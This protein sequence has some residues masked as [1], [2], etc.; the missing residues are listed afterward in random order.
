VKTSIALLLVLVLAF[1][2][3]RGRQSVRLHLRLR[4]ISA[5]SERLQQAQDADQR[6]R[7]LFDIG[8][9]EIQPLPSNR[10]VKA[11]AGT[12]TKHLERFESEFVV[13]QLS[14]ADSLEIRLSKATL[15]NAQ[16]RFADSL[17]AVTVDDEKWV[18]AAGEDQSRRL[19][20]IL[21][22]RG[23][24][25]YGLR[26]W[27][28]ALDHYQQLL[29]LEPNQLHAMARLGDC[30]Y[31]LGRTNEAL[32]AYRDLAAS[33]TQH[34]NILRNQGKLD[35]AAGHYGQA[36]EIQTRLIQRKG[37]SEL[38]SELATSYTNRGMAF[39]V[40]SKLAEAIADYGKAIAIQTRLIEHEGRHELSNDLAASHA[41][42]GNVLL[43]QGQLDAAISE[44]DRA[45]E[46]RTRLVEQE[47]RTELARDLAIVHSNRG[48]AR[49]GQRRLA[50]AIEDYSKAI[51]IHTRLAK[52]PRHE[53]VAGDLAM[54]HTNR[55]NVLLAQGRQDAAI[56][57]YDKAIE[58]QSR[59]V[60]RGRSELANDLAM[61]HIGRGI[62]RQTT[63]KLDAAI[64][65]YG[66][67]IEIRTRLVQ[68]GQSAL[69][70]D[71][72]KIHVKRG[73]TLLA[74]GRPKAAAGDYEKAIAIQTRLVQQQGRR[75]L[76]ADFAKSLRTAAW[77][78]ATHPLES[79]RDGIKS[80][81]Y[82]YK[83]CELT[84]WKDFGQIETLAAAYAETG[85]FLDAVTWQEK[86]VEFAS[87]DKSAQR[88]RLEL[89]KS[90]K[91]FRQMHAETE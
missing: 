32:T 49:R 60:K 31:S 56:E 20:R 76:A 22:V 51:E 85:N 87:Q 65:D 46:I 37:Q 25:F 29:L 10:Q 24:S 40:Q 17:A 55:G 78:Y 91:P 62:A 38:S 50:A 33:H 8:P 73:D 6:P 18:R 88:A 89:Y 52:Q 15:A 59:L 80:R 23:D 26:Q 11:L 43:V 1:L 69:A 41:N 71:L 72:A 35:R 53:D 47:G 67:A 58:I 70:N 90:G 19:A 44:Y 42:R 9:R 75:E 84:E 16:G 77:M 74:K 66:K 48:N 57:D 13:H 64:E 30:Q 12:L 4:E 5:L 83:A 27:A 21:Q 82:A 39:A 7:G 45:I 61:S 2:G 28:D 34:G 3:Y 63:S 86:A 54:N 68:Q 79:V 81:Q 14:D 36:I